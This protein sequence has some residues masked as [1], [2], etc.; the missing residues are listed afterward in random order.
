MGCYSADVFVDSAFSILSGAPWRESWL[1]RAVCRQ[2]SSAAQSVPD[3]ETEILN[4]IG[5]AVFGAA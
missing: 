2:R 5:L 3:F 1:R 4:G